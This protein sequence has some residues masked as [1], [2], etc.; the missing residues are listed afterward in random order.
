MVA[1]DT[2]FSSWKLKYRQYRHLLMQR[3]AT[4]RQTSEDIERQD[5]NSFETQFK[6]VQ[7]LDALLEIH[8]WRKVRDAIYAGAI[9]GI[10]VGLI[11]MLSIIKMPDNPVTLVVESKSVDFNMPADASWRWG[12]SFIFTEFNPSNLT[13]DNALKQLEAGSAETIILTSL[14]AD[15]GGSIR[16]EFDYD[17]NLNFVR[18]QGNLKGEIEFLLKGEK[19]PDK[20]S[21]NYIGSTTEA[22]RLKIRPKEKSQLKDITVRKISF[23]REVPTGNNPIKS[24]RI[25]ES[26]VIEGTIRLKDI[27]RQ[28]E[29]RAG[30]GIKLEGC[31]GQ[32]GVM[33]M[34]EAQKIITRFDASARKISLGKTNLAPSLLSWGYNGKKSAFFGAAFLALWGILWRVRKW[35]F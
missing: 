35:L 13:M 29:L 22:G 5:F 23:N 1:K 7:Q 6:Y 32:I 2:G 15:G 3:S 8:P 33:I 34:P 21:F 12:E 31:K 16:I 17:G 28:I 26:T 14:E 27:D 20:R 25:T 11:W 18:E 30:D 9:A 19:F 24:E 4:L 10:C